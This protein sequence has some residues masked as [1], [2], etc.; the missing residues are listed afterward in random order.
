MYN[1]TAADFADTG[2]WRLLVYIKSDGLEAFLVNT[3][4][5]E[6]PPQKLCSEKWEC[7][8][9]NLCKHL[10]DAVFKNPRLLDDFSTKIIMYDICTLF[11]PIQKIEENPGSE[12]EIYKSI[13][14]AE[15]DDVMY[16]RNK[17]VT[18]VWSMAPGVR[19]FLLRTFPGA[20]LASNLMEKIKIQR[21]RNEGLLLNTNLRQGEIDMV[22]TDYDKLISASTHRG[23]DKDVETLSNALIEAY[24][25]N[26]REIKREITKE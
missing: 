1:L 5:E 17:D 25:L 16:D 13:Y 18:A 6:V 8:R 11:I 2:Q 10:E 21:E 7:V 22:L 19:K 15:T 23:D 20:L 4:N 26:G 14:D 24:G 3:I 12:V 9:E